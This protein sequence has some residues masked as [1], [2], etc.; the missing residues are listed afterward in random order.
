M[1]FQVTPAAERRIAEL[2]IQQNRPNLC[3]KISVDGGGCSG[4][5]YKYEFVAFETEEGDFVLSQNSIKII[6]DS[7]SQEFMNGC[8]LDFIESLGSSYFEIKN[9]NAKAGCGCG[10]SFSV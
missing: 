6:I 5:M 7:I 3:L 1:E 4:F 9:P 2:I 8:K 10:N